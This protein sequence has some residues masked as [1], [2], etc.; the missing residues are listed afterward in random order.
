MFW[1]IFVVLLILWAVGAICHFAFSYL[2][3][4][5]ALIILIIRLVRGRAR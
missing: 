5:I 3:L 1:V 4:V 2:A